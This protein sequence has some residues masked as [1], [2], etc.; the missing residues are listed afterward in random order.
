MLKAKQKPIT[1]FVH[2]PS[3]Q[4]EAVTAA[5]VLMAE[6]ICHM[7]LSLSTADT[8]CKLVQKMC[9]DSKIAKGIYLHLSAIVNNQ[10][11]DYIF[12]IH[13]CTVY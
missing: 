5:E 12:Y 11:S 6:F 8:M 1:E 4:Q 2:Q 9:P 13:N 7:N 3:V 10:I